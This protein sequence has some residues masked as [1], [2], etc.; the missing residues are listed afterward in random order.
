[1]RS[2]GMKLSHHRW[3]ISPREPRDQKLSSIEVANQGPLGGQE[4]RHR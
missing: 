1:M 3:A 2:S 4:P